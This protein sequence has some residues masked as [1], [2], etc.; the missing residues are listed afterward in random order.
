MAL[1][2]KN[3]VITAGMQWNY[4]NEPNT[5]RELIDIRRKKFF[6]SYW[7]LMGVKNIGE[8]LEN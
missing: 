6:E 1:T 7:T 2:R 4:R 5:R 3:G 8:Q